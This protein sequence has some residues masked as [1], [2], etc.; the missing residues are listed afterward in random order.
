M[1]LSFIKFT[2]YAK[3]LRIAGSNSRFVSPRL[4]LFDDTITNIE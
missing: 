3:V 1:N 2:Q 4:L